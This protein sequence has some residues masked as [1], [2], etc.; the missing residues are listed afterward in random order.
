LATGPGPA[1]ADARLGE[2]WWLRGHRDH[3]FEHLG[4]A[5]A[6]VRGEPA[7]AG[8]AYVLSE[9]ARYRMLADPVP[10]SRGAGVQRVSCSS[11]AT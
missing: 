5:Q 8:K 2:L 11:S 3:A 1:E 9:L 4:R 6:L 10:P 7:S